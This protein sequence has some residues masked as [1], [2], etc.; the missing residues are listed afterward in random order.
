MKNVKVFL[1][2]RFL[3]LFLCFRSETRTL[4][5]YVVQKP[6]C[7]RSIVPKN[8]LIEAAVRRSSSKKAILKIA[9]YSQKNTCV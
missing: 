5:E 4:K 2:S 9:Q 3:R 7:F 8:H 6:D 1:D